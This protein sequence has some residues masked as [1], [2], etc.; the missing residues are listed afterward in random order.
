MGKN[1]HIEIDINAQRLR[2]CAGRKIVKEYPVSTARNGPG[3]LADSE[4]TPRGEHVIAEM[5]GGDCPLNT[6]FVSRQPSGE[7]YTP[8][9]KIKFPDRDWILTRIL[10]LQGAEPG[11][12]LYGNVDSHERFIYIH[13]S[14]DDVEMGRPG[15]RGCI[16]MRNKDVVELFN[17]V[18][19]G[20]RVTLTG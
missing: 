19:A 15:S 7:I 13:G 6:V 2:L 11:K 20:M 8:E 3:E 14:P 10:W 18:R 4:C 9:L 1:Y 17:K 16:R 5:I 12:N